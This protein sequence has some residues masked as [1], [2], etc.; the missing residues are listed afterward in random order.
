MPILDSRTLEFFSRSAEQTRRLGMRLGSLLEKG[1][2]VWLQGDLGS[3]KTTL[4]QGIAQG[5]GS[6]DPVTSPTFVIVNMYRR[7]DQV[8][9]Y[10]LDAYRL[11]DATEAEDLD[12]EL[13][14]EQGALVVEWPERIAAALPEAYLKINM[15]WI[16]DEQRGL[17]LLPQGERYDALIADF[18]RRVLGG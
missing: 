14:L 2:V 13:M 4:V 16:A 3:G 5:W 15:R 8:N 9:L 11:Q 12:M 7:P 1:D 10:H 6:L 17:V 18:R